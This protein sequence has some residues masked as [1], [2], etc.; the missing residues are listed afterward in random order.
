MADQT[1]SEVL[2]TIFHADLSDAANEDHWVVVGAQ[3]IPL[4]QHTEETRARALAQAGHLKSS[5][6][7][8]THFSA[9]S[10]AMPVNKVVRVHIKH[11]LRGVPDAKSEF[12]VTHSALY[13]PPASETRAA[14]RATGA[15]H[16]VG[17]I[18]YV[19][20]AQ[21]FLFHHP[22]L[23]TE[24]PEL[25]QPIH[26]Y[27]QNDKDISVQINNLADEMR[28]A[29]PPAESKG[30]AR[31]VPFTPNNPDAGFDGKTTYYQQQPT[32]AITTK[33][34]PALAPLLI[35]VKNDA[36]F[37]GTKWTVQPGQSVVSQHGPTELKLAAQIQA[38]GEGENWNAA[39]AVNSSVHGWQTSINLLNSSKK[40][41]KIS[42]SNTYMRYL[43]AYIRFFDAAGNAMKVPNWEPDDGLFAK[44]VGEVLDLQYDDVRYLGH[45]QPV[46][47]FMGIPIAGDPGR[48]DVTVTFPPN[49]VKAD[50]FGSGMG[51]G[52]NTWPKTPVVGGVLT[53]IFNLGVP[54]FM[55]GFA[56]A[57]QTYKPLYDIVQGLGKN[58]KFVAAVIGGAIAWFSGSSAAQAGVDWHA[59]ST[60]VQFLFDKS[61]TAA[62]VWVEGT[63]AAEEAAEQ[64]P[65]AGWIMIAINI[66]TGIAQMAQTI[67]EVATSPWNIENNVSTS[68]TT[69]VTLHPD[70]RNKSFPQGPAGSK[71]SYTVKMIYKDQTRPTVS[72][73]H[74][75]TADSTAVTLPAVFNNNTLG[76][77]VKFEADFYI[78]T[79][80]AGK[81]TTGF[82][83][84]DDAHAGQ[85]DLYLVQYPIPLDKN[86][87]Y[88]HAQLLT[89]QN[90]NYQ[91]MPTG[92]APQA[93]IAN[94]DTSPTGNSL[95]D[96]TGLT[97]SQRY[98]MLG[99][100]WQAAGL[101]IVS[102]STGAG[103]QLYAF[104]NINIPG[105]PMSAVKFPGCGFEGQSRLI[106]DP[107][108]PKFLMK[109]GQWML[110][111]NQRP[112]P[113]PNDVLL[114]EYYIDPRPASIPYEQGGGYHLRKIKLDNTT[115]FNTDPKQIS[116]GRFAYFP[117]SVALHPSGHLIGVSSQYHKLQ[118]IKVGAAGA[119]DINVPVSRTGSGPATDKNRP[120][121][122]FR[123]VAVACAYDG[124]VLVLEDT[125]SSS[126]GAGVDVVSRISA[127]DLFMNPVNRFF[128]GNN[129]PTSWL[130]L[131]NAPDYY[132]LDITAVGDDKLTYIYVLYYTGNGGSPADYHMAI[133][134]YG[135]T[136]PD[137]NPLVTTDSIPVAK[138]A[139]DMW[140]T[141]YTLNF[142]MM[143]DGKGN[144]AGPKNSTT[145][146]NGRTVPSASM[147]LPPV[148]K[149]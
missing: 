139:V 95:G 58:K 118:V 103:G 50:I 10:V 86:S 93:T 29:G 122:M 5:L 56:V 106:Y 49:A 147:W 73:P 82:V 30:W 22:D 52:P 77:E 54:A 140:H 128:D 23:I 127:Y 81:A 124:T 48:L 68:I 133:Y 1:S 69:N 91:W 28:K 137:S 7:T 113:D 141:L 136:K 130:Y 85:V 89:Y 72:Q 132:Y 47:S 63:L 17:P 57:A 55:L 100:A 79:W 43:G 112:V 125:K 15:V 80:L 101:G 83:A 142:Q 13:I 42:M 71:R 146:P 117:D 99:L 6:R 38:Q 134:Q 26:D 60:I 8:M 75:V 2:H 123:P 120:G 143:T 126:G 111:N 84:N 24:K 35:A 102:C 44:I 131:S 25:A 115:P 108:P 145:G 11:T 67:V 109:N 37:Q 107:F 96:W 148:P 97:L 104:Q 74:D 16:H 33:A 110:D 12:G 9:T 121:L 4:Q 94:R 90:G 66:A 31:L 34:L 78:D 41:I 51:T 65:F 76:G 3:R 144:P 92:N 40:Q 114:G 135:T 105:T 61:A 64:I 70:P 88:T 39:L 87:K 46:N 21:T 19:S 138:I 62:L 14:L 27:M 149:P 36:T 32:P 45:M 20:T 98:G 119:A 116:W 129:Q 53:G 18:D 59:F